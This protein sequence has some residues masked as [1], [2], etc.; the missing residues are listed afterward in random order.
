M[1]F[2]GNRNKLALLAIL[3]LIILFTLVWASYAE[4]SHE[5]KH[6]NGAFVCVQ[7]G[8]NYE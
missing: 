7:F 1:H 2:K 4:K 5:G 3:L 8:G 6:T